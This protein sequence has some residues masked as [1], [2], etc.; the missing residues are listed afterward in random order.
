L[1][2][3]VPY[4][5][6]RSFNAPY[7]GASVLRDVLAEMRAFRPTLVVTTHPFDTHPDHRAAGN[8]AALALE[9]L[10]LE[11]S[12]LPWTQRVRLLRFLVHHGVWPSPNGFHPGEPL[13]PP[14]DLARIGIRWQAQQLLPSARNAKRDALER[15]ASQLFTTPRYLRAFVRRNELFATDALGE[16][17]LTSRDAVRNSPVLSWRPAYDLQS[18]AVG[19]TGVGGLRVGLRPRGAPSPSLS[20]EV[21]LHGV[22]ANAQGTPTVK[23]SRLTWHFDGQRWR[24]GCQGA[25][26]PAH[27]RNGALWADV[28]APVIASRGEISLVV[29]AQVKRDQTVWDRMAEQVVRFSR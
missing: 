26:V 19:R 23:L 5:G 13:A 2:L 17:S 14:A 4:R 28:P 12:A 3:R 15:Y 20:Y 10:R 21:M 6:A 27:L 7:C 25:E 24:A 8:F 11:K 1:K 18:L 9:T 22:S 29:G 16:N